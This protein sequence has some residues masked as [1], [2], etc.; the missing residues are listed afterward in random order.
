MAICE[1]WS[2]AIQT[3]D[4]ALAHIAGMPL[5]QF[6]D[7][8][9]GLTRQQGQAWTS[10]HNLTEATSPFDEVARQFGVAEDADVAAA[11]AIALICKA[12]VL[13]RLEESLTEGEFSL[14]LLC[15]AKVD[16]L[17]PD[18]IDVLPQFIARFG[19]SRVLELVQS[20]PA[21]P[22]LLPLVTALQQELGQ[23]PLVAK[24]VDEV[25][26]DIRLDLLRQV[27]GNTQGW[28]CADCGKDISGVT[29]ARVDH[30]VPVSRGGTHDLGNLQLLC[31]QCNVRKGAKAPKRKPVVREVGLNSHS[32]QV[33]Q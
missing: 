18:F 12:A 6:S 27:V 23:A 11:A 5:P 13:D 3:H 17:L 10:K 8:V 32:Q 15:L 9:A 24:E 26:K 22:L 1:K 4:Y 21:A 28:L 14:L 16:E 25:A 20:S 2:E 29:Q 7:W 33:A 30:I 31:H 19:P